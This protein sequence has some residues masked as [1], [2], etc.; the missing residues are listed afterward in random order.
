MSVTHD[1][2]CWPHY[3]QAALDGDKM[4]EFR[5]NDRG[6]KV[7]DIL[8]LREWCPAREKYTLREANFVVTYVLD[9]GHKLKGFC[10]LGIR[11]ISDEIQ[12]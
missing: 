2:K 12:A 10:I 1:L 8:W 4:F 6:Y 11:R 9:I 3:F 5:E 7:G